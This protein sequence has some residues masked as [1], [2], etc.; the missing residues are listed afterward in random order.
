DYTHKQIRQ[1]WK[2]HLDPK[3]DN[4]RKFIVKWVI[5]N[6]GP[7]GEISFVNLIPV[8]EN[9]FGKSHSENKLKNFWKSRER[10]RNAKSRQRGEGSKLRFDEEKSKTMSTLSPMASPTITHFISLRK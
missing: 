9:R 3:H 4:E 5:E 10:S 6:K 1:R 8:M 2:N 7:N